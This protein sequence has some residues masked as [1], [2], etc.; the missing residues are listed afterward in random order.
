VNSANNGPY[1]DAI[2]QELIPELERRFRVI[3]EP[4]CAHPVGRVDRR[5]E[6]AALQIFHPDFSAAP[7]HCPDS[8]TFT[9]VEGINIY[10]D[11]N[12]FYKQL[13]LAQGADRQQPDGQR[14][15][16][17]DLAA[18]QLLRAGQRHRGR[19]EQLD[20]WS[21]V[22]GPIGSDGYFQPLFGQ[23]DRRHPQG[24]GCM[25]G[26]LRPALLPPDA[27]VHRDE[28]RRQAVFLHRR[29]RHLL[30]N[31]STKELRSG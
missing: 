9:D 3:R 8:V 29:R 28:D 10:E 24:R 31:N 15:A 27:L 20:V 22:F 23:E 19:G 13:R 25:E 6:A 14:P 11:E 2:M 5:M 21:S 1:G 7:G 26:A 12:A 18:A 4:L 17:D 16:G 30:L